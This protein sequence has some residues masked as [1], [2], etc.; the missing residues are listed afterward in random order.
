MDGEHAEPAPATIRAFAGPRRRRRGRRAGGRVRHARRPDGP[1]D[2]PRGGAGALPDDRRQ[3]HRPVDVRRLGRRIDLR[4][5]GRRRRHLPLRDGGPAARRPPPHRPAHPAAHRAA[6]RRA[7]ALGALRRGRRR[8]SRPR[9]SPG[10]QRGRQPA[11]L[12]RAGGGPPA[13]LPLPL[14]RLRPLRLG[15]HRHPGEPR[16]AA[17][18]HRGARRPAQPPAAGRAP[19]PAA[20]GQQPGGRLQDQ[21]GG[22]GHRPG[23]DLALGRDHRPRRGPGIAARD[24]GLA[25]RPAGRPH[26]PLPRR[27]ERLP[28]RAGAARAAPRRWP[29]RPL[30]GERPPGA[31]AGRAGVLASGR[32]HRLRPRPGGGP[33]PVAARGRGSGRRR[34]GRHR[35]GH[36][37]PR[38]PGRQRRRGPADRSSPGLGAPLRQRPVQR[39]A[40]RRLPAR[41][42]DPPGR[43]RRLPR[44]AQ[45]RRGRPPRRGRGRL[46]RGDERGRAA[47][48]RP[49][50]RRRGPRAP[51]PR[52]PAAVLRPAPRRPQPAL[53]PLRHPP[54]RPH[55]RPRAQL[56]GQLARYLPELGGP[57]AVVPRL[58][59]QHGGGVRQRL[60]RGRV[61]SLPADPRGHRLGG[62]GAGRPLE[63]H[64]LLGRPPGD[65]PA[66]AA[67]SAARS[68]PRRAGR[69][70]R[71]AHLQLRRR[72]LPPEALRRP[73]A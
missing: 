23:P 3:R 45:P 10:A 18:A 57:G 56:R 41:S 73:A 47:R 42:R 62:G 48:G 65:L 20:A 53:E 64:R 70:A 16:P 54:A 9:A 17:G 12:Q 32:R 71:R 19:R 11:D 28:A 6:G 8:A 33:A 35:R 24:H 69:H 7:G 67:R 39:H 37:E 14:G 60:H 49:R 68:R 63:Q 2:P 51:G 50:H 26:P 43:P 36:P 55:R 31:A 52:V 58:P 29:A 1:G 44:R 72:A 5:R 13:R 30:P 40:R 46:A 4:P 27:R 59:A 22:P 25:R 15:A 21:R 61:Q 66:Q 38:A 34:G